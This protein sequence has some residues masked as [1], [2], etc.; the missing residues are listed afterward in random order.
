MHN[1]FSYFA[2][3]FHFFFNHKG[4]IKKYVG[5]TNTASYILLQFFELTEMLTD[6]A[7]Y[8]V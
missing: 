3:L 6:L 1:N 7:L 2:M 5:S 4:L 8:K